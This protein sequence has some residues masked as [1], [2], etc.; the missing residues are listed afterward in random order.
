MF[1]FVAGLL[2]GSVAMLFIMSLM[3]AAK[4]GDHQL[5]TFQN[6]RAY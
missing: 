4:K 5:E 3:V 2:V 6:E 1:T